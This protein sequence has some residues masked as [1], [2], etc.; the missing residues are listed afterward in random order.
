MHLSSPCEADETYVLRVSITTRASSINHAAIR[1]HSRSTLA[2]MLALFRVNDKLITGYAYSRTPS[3]TILNLF[4]FTFM[5]HC[6]KVTAR[7]FGEGDINTKMISETKIFNDLR[8]S[9]LIFVAILA[10]TSFDW[11][12][13]LKGTPPTATPP[14]SRL[15]ELDARETGPVGP[16]QSLSPQ[17]L[18]A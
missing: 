17:S 12:R 15:R 1:L 4:S 10:F 8:R 3:W 18:F 14:S 2:Y 7:A 16:Y 11:S 9:L 13:P 6:F 5:F